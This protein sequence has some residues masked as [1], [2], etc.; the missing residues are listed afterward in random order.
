VQ[1]FLLV[2]L[3]YN[4][5]D[6]SFRAVA[7]RHLPGIF[8]AGRGSDVFAFLAYFGLLGAA[9]RW[10]LLADRL[11]KGPIADWA[12]CRDVHLGGRGEFDRPVPAA[13]GPDARGDD[14]DRG[15][16]GQPLVA[17]PAGID[18]QTAAERR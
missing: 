17:P 3:D 1:K 12:D 9:P 5:P 14:V 8:T 6:S 16:T 7:D 10:W 4:V 18:L 13:V 2:Q 11:R 15:A